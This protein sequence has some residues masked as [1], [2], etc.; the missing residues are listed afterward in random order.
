MEPHEHIPYLREVV[1]FL[2]AAG[3]IVP[4]FHR[5][6][7]S[8][9][10]GFLGAG[11][12]LGP[13]GLGLFAQ[14]IGSL[15]YAVIDDIEGVKSLASL[16]VIFL[17]FMIG[18]E[19]SLERLWALRRMVF[20]LGTLQV[21]ITA[22]VLGAIA[23]AFGNTPQ[24]SVIFGSC[25]AL[26]STAI[27]MQ[28]L[29]ERRQVATT[30][31]RTSF[32]ILLLQ[33]L[34]V[35]PIL[36]LVGVLSARVQGDVGAALLSSAVKALGAIVLILA[37][38]RLALRPLFRLVTA[39]RG[40]DLF[41]AATLLTIVGTAVMTGA[42]GLSMALGAF[43]AGLALAETEFRHQIE[44]DIEP[45]K[46]LLLGLFFMSV[47]MGIDFRAVAQEPL[48]LAASVAGLFLIKSVITASL[49]LL[50]RL[51]RH[52]AVEAGLL[53]GQGGEFAFVVVGLALTRGLVPSETAQ[54]MLIVTGLTMAVTPA[55]A[56]AARKLAERIER[57][58]HA[59]GAGVTF[60]TEGLEGHVIIAGFGRVG[61]T[62]V[63]FFDAQ[64][65]PYVALDLDGPSVSAHR[66]AG[67]PVFYGDASRT[68]M[69]RRAHVESAQALVIT[70]DRP[71]AAQH[72]VGAVRREWPWLPIFARARDAVHAK[73]LLQAGATA[74]VPETVEA[75]LQ[76]G[77]RVLEG[78]G[79]SPD[80][81]NAVVGQQR[82]LLLA[83]L[84][85]A[86][87]SP[88]SR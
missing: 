38:G 68:D 64:K 37:I 81:V 40:P 57:Q 67:L 75:S 36:F 18:L 16:G 28:L 63:R 50:F 71:I 74:V 3:L 11:V 9:V 73:A 88:S 7:V 80:I 46:G 59:E 17:L 19:L 25:L 69:L 86:L 34:A 22:L 47:G 29:A 39:A 44:V 27:V 62:L 72:T 23:W 78:V 33:D 48:W 6:H 56:H 2:A 51:P 66:A 8:P 77:A 10:L 41:V 49:C 79:T 55:L 24:A 5:L 20:G 32:A 45:F 61:Q 35:V 13:F 70:M 87:V 76:L 4:L 65:L 82:E 31:G 85:R 26:S 15:R 54:F 83:E 43:L 60:Q 21:V 14:D 30:L 53:L 42:A 1:V 12:L 58:E 52:I 84:E